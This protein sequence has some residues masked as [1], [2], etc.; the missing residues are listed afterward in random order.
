MRT[1]TI[2]F[3]EY[4][5]YSVAKNC[6]CCD[7]GKRL[8]RQRSFTQTEN[9]WN[10]DVDGGP[11]TSQQII[12][13]C[14][15]EAEAWRTAP[16]RCA[17]CLEAWAKVQMTPVE[18]EVEVYNTEHSTFPGVYF[19]S[20]TA[21]PRDSRRVAESAAARVVD[22]GN[23]EAGDTDLRVVLRNEVIGE[24]SRW[25]LAPHPRRRPDQVWFVA[26]PAEQDNKAAGR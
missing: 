16:E 6:K 5:V 2:R 14:Q 19:G 23:A 15:A 4:G 25:T 1:E 11:K 9:P 3:A 8:R 26:T 10:R 22:H 24:E 18:F 7:C 21:A 20:V 12:T 17:G 13:E